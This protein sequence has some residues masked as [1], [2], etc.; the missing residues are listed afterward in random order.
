MELFYKDSPMPDSDGALFESLLTIMARLRGEG[1]CPWDREQTRDSLKAYLIEEAYEALEALEEGRREAIVEELGDLL[2]Q[3]VFHARI[4]QEHGE[5]TIT[6][7]L[8]RLT[9][10]MVHRHPHVFADSAVSSAKEALAQWESIK[11]SEANRD[12]KIRSVLDGVPRSLPAL[13]R[14]QRTQV[15]AARVGFDWKGAEAAWAKVREETREVE[16]SLGEGDRPR[17]REELGDLFFSLVNVARL[18]DMDAEDCL[19][20]AIQ[21]F[22][23]RF[24][25]MEA[26]VASEGGVNLSDAPMETLDR[27]WEA[28]KAREAHPRAGGS[29]QNVARHPE[30]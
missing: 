8:R 15:K 10:K 13:L 12:G 16:R 29:T 4:G 3:V 27:A 18:L 9:E 19:Q 11:Q 24:A 21:K 25:E 1:G 23:R 6:D 20:R 5:F 17:I 28:V 14:A 26:A 2:F 7:V 30:V 22:G